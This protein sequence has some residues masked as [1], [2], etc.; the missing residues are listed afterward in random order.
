MLQLNVGHPDHLDCN[1][2]FLSLDG[3]SVLEEAAAVSVLEEAAAVSVEE[4]LSW[5]WKRCP[6]GGSAV[7][8]VEALSRWS[9]SAYLIRGGCYV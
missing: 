1:C 3:V 7:L 6:G 2:P 8:V 5:W 4:A 9:K